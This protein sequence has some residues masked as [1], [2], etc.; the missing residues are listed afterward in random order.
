LLWS[1]HASYQPRRTKTEQKLS[2][3]DH[4]TANHEPAHGF[5]EL[6]SLGTIHDCGRI[7]P[8]HYHEEEEILTFLSGEVEVIST[9]ISK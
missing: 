3:Q 1:R 8:P 9:I 6:G 5:G 2:E 4:G 7:H